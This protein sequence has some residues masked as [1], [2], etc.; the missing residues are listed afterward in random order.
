MAVRLSRTSDDVTSWPGA[1][2]RLRREEVALDAL[3]AAAAS[4][5]FKGLLRS[6]KAADLAG[7]VRVTEDDLYRAEDAADEIP[8]YAAELAEEIASVHRHLR[9]RC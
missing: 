8:H 5:A 6:I 2:G 1:K 9:S 3:I 4:P 7:H